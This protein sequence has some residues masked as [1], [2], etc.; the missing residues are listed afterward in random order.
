MWQ[1]HPP[2]NP[3]NPMGKAPNPDPPVEVTAGQRKAA[4]DAGASHIASDGAYCYCW[5]FNSVFQAQWYGDRFGGWWAY[6]DK[7]PTEAIKLDG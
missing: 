2:Y 1:Y 5:R 7:M 4:R 6:G 3:F